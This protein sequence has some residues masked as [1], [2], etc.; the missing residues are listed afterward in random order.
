[1][2]WPSASVTIAFLTSCWRPRTPRNTLV[3]P[4]RTSVLTAVDL[5]VEQLLDRRL[6]LRLG[7]VARDLEHELV[8]LRRDRRLFGDDRRDD[9]VVV[10]RILAHLNRA[11]SASTAALVSTSFSRRMMS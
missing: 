7:R 11:S 3:L 8:A 9:E 2:R 4:L 10:A 5:D 1:M 6:D